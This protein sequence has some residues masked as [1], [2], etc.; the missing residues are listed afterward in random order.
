MTPMTTAP[1]ASRLARVIATLHRIIGAPDYQGYL[2]YM[3]RKHP[4]HRVL[5]RD[6]HARECLNRRYTQP[7]NR[8]C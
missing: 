1:R 7:G 6:E 3:K 4:G 8:C 2:A 5:S